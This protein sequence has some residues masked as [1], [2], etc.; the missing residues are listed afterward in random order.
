MG[1][2]D[3]TTTRVSQCALRWTRAADGEA[4]APLVPVYL[5]VARTE[6][7]LHTPL[8][9][10]RTFDASLARLRAVALRAA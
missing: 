1:L 7:L 5:D 3:G 9:A 4:Q 6:L 2:N 10:A 8:P